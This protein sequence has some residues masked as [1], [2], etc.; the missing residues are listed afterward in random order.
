MLETYEDSSSATRV[1][2]KDSSSSTRTHGSL[3]CTSRSTYFR[4]RRLRTSHNFRLI[5]LFAGGEEDE[6]VFRMFD[7][8]LN[9]HPEFEALSYT[10]GGTTLSHLVRT[11][12]GIIRVTEN[13][14][15]ALRDLR[16]LFRNRILW[17][18]A[19]C[20]NQLSNLEKSLQVP[21]M[22]RI[23]AE[24]K[25]V[26]I[27]IG[28]KSHLDL[29]VFFDYFRRGKYDPNMHIRVQSTGVLSSIL[30][31]PW[32]S[33][34]WVL[35]E[36][37]FA[38][39]AILMWGRATIHWTLL[40]TAHL[41][42]LYLSPEDKTGKIPPVLLFSG[43]DQ[44][45]I[46]DVTTFLTTARSCDSSDPRDKIN[47]LLGL[48][49]GSMATKVVPDYDKSLAMLCT[50]FFQDIIAYNNHLDILSFRGRESDQEIRDV[51]DLGK[52]VN[53]FASEA[54]KAKVGMEVAAQSLRM[55]KSNMDHFDARTLFLSDTAIWD[56]W[57]KRRDTKRD[58]QKLQE[59]KGLLLELQE[60]CHALHGIAR[61]VAACRVSRLDYINLWG[62]AQKRGVGPPDLQN[63]KKAR[64][65]WL[66]AVQ[67]EISVRKKWIKKHK[68]LA[69][70]QSRQIEAELSEL[71]SLEEQRQKEAGRLGKMLNETGGDQEYED[72]RVMVEKTIEAYKSSKGL[73]TEINEAR[74]RLD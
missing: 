32:W 26:V 22:S 2:C 34:V 40:S 57:I 42:R 72:I 11:T 31:R 1:A 8:N 15:A 7:S 48:F 30:S 55:D 38:R 35:Q 36:V 29:D 39:S 5:E 62:S 74:N 14:A 66:V 13:C 60:K 3:N 37:A 41:Q 56:T 52:R 51:E 53:H 63:V 28:H 45:P 71:V 58:C 70:D 61:K 64:E 67:A 44:R 25:Q 73:K 54:A 65:D 46:R 23:Y 47:A 49:G 6:I 10:W 16:Y 19:I 43:N 12:T 24:A 69:R 4:Y 17:I 27:H 59:A 50:T 9:V 33:R 68:T 18:D 20:I 21:L